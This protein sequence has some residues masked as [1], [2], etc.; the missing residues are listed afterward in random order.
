MQQTPSPTLTIVRPNLII[1][2]LVERPIKELGTI[3]ELSVLVSQ[4]RGRWEEFGP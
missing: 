2:R 4:L 1:E 3:G